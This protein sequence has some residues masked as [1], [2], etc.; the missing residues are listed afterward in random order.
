MT[1]DEELKAAKDKFPEFEVAKLVSGDGAVQLIARSPSDAEFTRF[2]TRGEKGSKFDAIKGL[3]FDVV[4]YPAP[5][6]LS[7]IMRK[8]PGLFMEFAE[9][10]MELAGVTGQAQAVK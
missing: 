4:V 3:F 6:A 9:P 5:D 1:I 10:I 8:K 2:M 7:A